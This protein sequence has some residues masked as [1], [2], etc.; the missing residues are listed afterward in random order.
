ML[1]GLIQAKKA[2]PVAWR[3]LWVLRLLRQ[4]AEHGSAL[5]GGQRGADLPGRAV[6]RLQQAQHVLRHLVGLG[7]HRRAGLLQDLRAG[8]LGGFLRVIHVADAAA[9]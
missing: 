7:Q 5:P 6:L 3:G 8:Q 2:P 4:L 9:G 1:G